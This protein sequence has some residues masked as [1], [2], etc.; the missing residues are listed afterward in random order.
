MEWTLLCNV[1]TLTSI[2][3]VMP[4]P[5]AYGVYALFQKKKI[6]IILWFFTFSGSFYLGFGLEIL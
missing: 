2:L 6:V 5:S 3:Y 4:S 1:D